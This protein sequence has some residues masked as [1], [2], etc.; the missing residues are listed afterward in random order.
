MWIRKIVFRFDY[1]RPLPTSYARSRAFPPTKALLP[2]R[3]SRAQ[4][5][6]KVWPKLERSSIVLHRK[7]RLSKPIAVHDCLQFWM[8]IQTTYRPLRLHMPFMCQFIPSALSCDAC[9]PITT[10][11]HALVNI[12]ARSYHCF[13]MLLSFSVSRALRYHSSSLCYLTTQM[14]RLRSSK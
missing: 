10:P 8:I 2:W 11:L 13:R 14:K 4:P 3:A 7:N 9:I 6:D 5:D 12:H 1:S